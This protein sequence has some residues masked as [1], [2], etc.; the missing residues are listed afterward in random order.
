MSTLTIPPRVVP[1]IRAGAQM[2]IAAAA[3]QLA[4]VIGEA[5]SRGIPP[6]CEQQRISQAWVLTDLLGWPD[7]AGEPVELD[8]REHGVALG[9]ALDD[10]AE[11]LAELVAD[12]EEG[13]QRASRKRDLQELLEFES[14][15]RE[16]IERAR[17]M[18]ITATVPAQVAVLLRAALYAELGR[19]CE[20][21]PGATPQ[22][23]KRAGWTPVLRRIDTAVHGLNALGWAEPD[24]QQPL[25]IA[26]DAALIEVLE[27]DAEQWEWLSGQAR[28]G[29][30]SRSCGRARGHDRPVSHC[31]PVV[32]LPLRRDWAEGAGAPR[33]SARTDTRARWTVGRPKPSSRITATYPSIAS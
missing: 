24:E 25:T 19:A 23:N 30:G 15:A 33:Y 5:M 10:N 9:A 31:P 8:V 32:A 1:Y 28:N 7:E 17:S 22:S 12:T 29:G 20:D 4:T 14:T 2:Q 26:L 27:A 11:Q 13:L 3:E 18:R 21:A 16:A 6:T